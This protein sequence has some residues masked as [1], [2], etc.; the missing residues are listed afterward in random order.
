MQLDP[1]L[2]NTILVIPVVNVLLFFNY[3]FHS[4]SLPGSFGFAIIALTVA[5][6][7][8]LHPTSKQQIELAKKMQDMKP[9]LDILTEKH[10]D[11]KKKLQEEQLKLYKEM[12]INPAAGCLY[13][14]IQIP[15][16][17]GLYNALNL[18]LSNGAY[19][20]VAATINKVVYFD[21]L[22]TTSIDPWFFG[23]NVGI[24][25]SAFQQQGVHYLLVPVITAI[26]Q[27]YQVKVTTAQT[28]VVKKVPGKDKEKTQD[29]QS[30]MSSQMLYLFPLML[31]YF[32]YVL[33]VGL[34]LYWNIFSI[35][36]IFQY[37]GNPLTL[38]KNRK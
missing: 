10:K 16:I 23:F 4:I 21:F 3:I 26:L 29:M 36:T 5:I 11:D 20:K 38:W 19:S 17:I 28:P 12:G 30:M 33:P 32:A 25:P 35:F 8:L 22:K 13:A 1:N 34:S 31:G 15:V 7:L 27:Y 24:A 6:R 9:H 18:F 14:L 2:F 37:K